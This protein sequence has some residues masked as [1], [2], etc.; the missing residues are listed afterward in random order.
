MI[1]KYYDGLNKIEIEITIIRCSTLRS[2]FSEI[3]LLR[4]KRDKNAS[5]LAAMK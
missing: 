5:P 2:D 3:G 1:A 4:Y